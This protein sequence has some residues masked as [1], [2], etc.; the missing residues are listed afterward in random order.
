MLMTRGRVGTACQPRVE[1]AAGRT[2]V[3]A[4]L[5]LALRDK[6]GAAKPRPYLRELSSRG[7]QVTK[8]DTGAKPRPTL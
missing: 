5:C 1:F 2:R 4:R 8:E 7:D 6:E 3:G